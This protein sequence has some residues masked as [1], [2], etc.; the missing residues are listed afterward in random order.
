MNL[1]LPLVFVL[2]GILFRVMPHPENFSPIFAIA[3]FGGTYFADRRL[4]LI[5]PIIAL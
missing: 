5:I 2:V 1:L 4:A 3:L